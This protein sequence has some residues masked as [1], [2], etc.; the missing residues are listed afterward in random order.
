M[1]LAVFCRKNDLGRD[2][3]DID[4]FGLQHPDRQPGRNAGV[5]GVAARLEDFK[6]RVGGQV[7]AGGNNVP[8]AH[9]GHAFGAHLSISGFAAVL[10]LQSLDSTPRRPC[11]PVNCHELDLAQT[12]ARPAQELVNWPQIN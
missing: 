1:H 8:G 10:R 9:D 7:M 2:A 4:L 11:N 12:A 5:D 6:G 3:A